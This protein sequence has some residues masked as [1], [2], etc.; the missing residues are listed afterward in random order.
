MRTNIGEM[1]GRVWETLAPTKGGAR[2]PC[3]LASRR[4][5]IPGIFITYN[6]LS[7]EV[8][9]MDTI[10]RKNIGSIGWIERSRDCPAIRRRD[11]CQ[12]RDG[13]YSGKRH[14]AAC[15]DRP[16]LPFLPGAHRRKGAAGAQR[17]MDKKEASV[18]IEVLLGTPA[19]EILRYADGNNVSLV[20]MASRGRS[21]SGPWLLGNIAA[22]VI[23]SFKQAGAAYQGSSRQRSPSAEE[24]GEKDSGAFGWFQAGR[25]GHSL[26]RGSG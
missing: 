23:L 1:A 25:G 3:H 14:R 15:R 8:N 13:D 2:F 11:R 22:K 26:C 4:A 19:S 12:R 5:I 16:S 17:L 24:I 6:A 10:L 7:E 9:N 21:S 20:T 18:K